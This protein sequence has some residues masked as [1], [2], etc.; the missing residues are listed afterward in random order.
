MLSEAAREAPGSAVLGDE[1]VWSAL[2]DSAEVSSFRGD[3]C[4][5]RE[6]VRVPTQF[7]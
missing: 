7:L 4:C 1:T 3:G 2:V 6:R 5:Q